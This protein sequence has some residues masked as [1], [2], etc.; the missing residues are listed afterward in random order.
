MAPALLCAKI[1]PQS[2]FG[3]SSLLAKFVRELYKF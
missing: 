1:T 2:T 3:I